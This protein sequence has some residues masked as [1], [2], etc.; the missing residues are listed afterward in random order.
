[1]EFCVLWNLYFE[2]V[3]R[4]KVIS[5]ENLNDDALA[6]SEA[7]PFLQSRLQRPPVFHG[8]GGEMAL[9]ARQKGTFWF[10][11][12]FNFGQFIVWD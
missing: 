5:E 12:R 4:S 8:N 1:M 3:P 9:C 6:L 2:S 10:G 7:T 11:D